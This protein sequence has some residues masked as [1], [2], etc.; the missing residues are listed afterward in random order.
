VT[1][2]QAPEL[3]VVLVCEDLENAAPALDRVRSQ[4]AIGRIEVLLVG[5]SRQ[6]A[7]LEIPEAL[8]ARWIGSG[9][10]RSLP[11]AKVEAVHA[12]RAP[13]VVF[14]ETHAYPDPGWAGALIEA[15]REECSVVGPAMTNANPERALSWAN[16]FLFFGPWLG[17]TEPARLESLPPHNSS[18]KRAALLDYAADLRALLE[19][20]V[21]LHRRMAADGHV[22]L[23]EPNALVAHVNPTVLRSW[24]LI[25]F[26][27][28][29]LFAAVR[30]RDW[31]VWRRTVYALGSPLIPALALARMLPHWRRARRT[32]RVPL[33]ALP[34]L[35]VGLIFHAAGECAGYALGAGQARATREHF[36]LHREDYLAP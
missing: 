7:P 11:A 34:L 4:T 15:H 29:R 10:A 17:R 16:M 9:A 28:A 3:S 32:E 25:T 20:E 27:P 35:A 21:L 22:L 5:L 14:A 31:P 1:G 13:V 18:Y 12:A 6:A 23:F 36:E 8:D 19:F 2:A 30:A 33:A 26:A 24:A